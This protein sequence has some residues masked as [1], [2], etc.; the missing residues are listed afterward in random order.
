MKR[1]SL[2][3]AVATLRSILW[4]CAIA[5]I[6][7]T[8]ATVAA[9]WRA[10]MVA[11]STSMQPLDQLLRPLLW[12]LWLPARAAESVFGWA[13]HPFHSAPDVVANVVAYVKE[14]FLLSVLILLVGRACLAVVRELRSDK[15][16]DEV[17]E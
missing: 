11:E 13:F 3:R 15:L 8:S 7:A 12:I 16:G 4:I 5:W 14:T 9:A 17:G 2:A 6:V 10:H 1:M